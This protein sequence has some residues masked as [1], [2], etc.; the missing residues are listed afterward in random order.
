[1][2][3]QVLLGRD[4]QIEPMSRADWESEIVKAPEV[5][6]ERL[7]FMSTDHHRVRYFVV[8]N[9]ARSGRPVSIGT[10]SERLQL[11]HEAVTEIAAELERNLF[12]LVR[13]KAGEVSWAYPVTVDR[14]PHK[15]T[16]STG[17]RLYGA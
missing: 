17:E 9:L 8:A 10:I 5:C 15:L 7:R 12:F 3:D 4:H 6:A 16:F 11:T 13:N 2:S 1:M 14:T